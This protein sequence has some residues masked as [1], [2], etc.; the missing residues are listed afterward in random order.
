MPSVLPRTTSFLPWLLLLGIAAAAAGPC[1]IAADPVPAPSPTAAA[2]PPDAAAAPSAADPAAPLF[3]W[4]LPGEAGKVSLGYGEVQNPRTGRTIFNDGVFIAA[5]EGAPVLAVADGIV[6]Q[7]AIC[8]FNNDLNYMQTVGD[9]PLSPAE[10][11]QLHAE[12]KIPPKAVMGYVSLDLGGGLTVFYGGLAQG[13]AVKRGVSVKKGD[14]IGYAG[15]FRVVLPD[16]HVRISLSRF[17][18]PLDIGP[19]LGLAGNATGPGA[20]AAAYDPARTFAPEVLREDFRLC[21]EAL[22]EGHPGL[23]DYVAK[24]ELDA[25]FAAAEAKLDRPL[26]EQEFYGVLA[27][28]VGRLGCSH[29][30]LSRSWAFLSSPSR[31]FQLRPRLIEGRWRVGADLKTEAGSLLG[32]EI[33]GING[34]DMASIAAELEPSV[35]TDGRSVAGRRRALERLFPYLYYS[36]YGLPESLTVQLRLPGGGR[37]EYSV[38]DSLRRLSDLK[39]LPKPVEAVSLSLLDERT[40]LLTV[41]DFQTFDEDKVVGFF[42]ELEEKQVPSLIVDLRDNPGGAAT[43]IAFLY[44]FFTDQPF[45]LASCLKANTN[46]DYAFFAHTDGFQ[47]NQGWTANFRPRPGKA[48]VYLTPDMA[49]AGQDG[50]LALQQPQPAH[51]YR[52]KVAVLTNGLTLSAAGVFAALLHRDGRATVIGEETGAGYYRMNGLKFPKLFLPGTRMTLTVPLVQSVFTEDLSPGI[53]EGRGVLPHHQIE[54]RLEDLLSGADRELAFAQDLLRWGPAVLK[55]RRLAAPV[56]V[57][58]LALL[59]LAVVVGG[60]TRQRVRR[61]S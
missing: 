38:P 22:E 16:P 26:T 24:E 7:A 48:G 35:V 11:E 23:Y 15:Y 52:G 53:P 21:R 45:R 59:S 28:I 50:D 36:T 37:I 18:K 49:A 25:L 34:V 29:T 6:T 20:R 61:R 31:R 8:V 2:P 30:F 40:A 51:R 27:P 13:L 14:V 56:G 60:R 44:G 19:F 3:L 41:R 42:R 46:G 4:P 32:A 33:L 47:G 55:A 57:P 12:H 1:A 54:P 43:N 58:F 39:Q 10:L 17:G 5:E 9:R